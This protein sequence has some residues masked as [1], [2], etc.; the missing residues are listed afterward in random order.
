[1]HGAGLMR[2]LNQYIPK[3]KGAL[4]MSYELISLI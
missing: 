1:M 3:E 4:V 2:E